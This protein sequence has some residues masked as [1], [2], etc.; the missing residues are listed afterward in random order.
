MTSSS[1]APATPNASERATSR[2]QGF[3]LLESAIAIAATLLAMSGIYSIVLST[4]RLFSDQMKEHALEQAGRRVMGRATEYLRAAHPS[5]IQ[6]A[7]LLNSSYVTFQEVTGFNGSV[8]ELGPV[9]TLRFELAPDET[10]NGADDNGNGLADEGFLVLTPD[11]APSQWLDGNLLG[12]R[13]TA[14]SRGIRCEAD[15]G[16]FKQKEGLQ[17]KTFSRTVTFRN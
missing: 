5:T 6:P 16:V 14:V 11:G 7:L 13:F 3:T 2:L 1:A 9:T 12:L 4:E 15:V 10:L 8:V 17:T